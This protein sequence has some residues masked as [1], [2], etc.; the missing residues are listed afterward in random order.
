MLKFLV[1]VLEAKHDSGALNCPA[2]ALISF[3]IKEIVLFLV[4]FYYWKWHA[5][6][7][8]CSNILADDSHGSQTIFHSS[9]EWVFGKYFS[10][11]SEIWVLIRSASAKLL[12]FSVEAPNW[13][14]ALLMS[15]PA[16]VLV[17]KILTSL[18]VKVPTCCYKCL[19]GQLC[20]L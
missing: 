16:Y 17:K 20:L 4:M 2:T 18:V 1:R 15:N 8:Q 13:G 12:G 7:W 5:K 6:F 10:F 19:K 14:E 9:R 3:F 11:L